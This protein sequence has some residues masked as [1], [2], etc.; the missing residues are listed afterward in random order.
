MPVI[1]DNKKIIPA[2]L[3]SFR[4]EIDT[5]E[6]G[7]VKKSV[8]VIT[9]TGT[10]VAY[11]GSPDG[12]GNFWTGSGYPPDTPQSEADNPDKRL[13]L[14]RD[15]LGALSNLF[16]QRG[17]TLEIQPY[18]GSASITAITR[19]RNFD[20]DQGL[21]YDKIDYT[22]TLEA[23]SIWFGSKEYPAVNN[24]IEETWVVEPNDDKQRTYKVTHTVSAVGRPVYNSNGVLVTKA[25]VFA[26]DNMVSPRLFFNNDIKNQSL[27][28]PDLD[29]WGLYDFVRVEN[30]DETNGRYSITESW[31]L[32]NGGPYLEDY[33]VSIRSSV[34][35]NLTTVS[36]DGVITGFNTDN[37]NPG[38]ASRF[39]NAENGLSTVLGLLFSRA[40][41]YSGVA[42]NSIP[43]STTIGKNPNTG[44]ITYSYE[45]NN[46]PST[47][48]SGAVYESVIV[49]DDYPADVFAR[50]VCVLRA[51]GPVLQPIG[52]ITEKR[53]TVQIDIQMPPMNQIFTPSKPSIS[54]ILA[55]NYPIGAIQGPY[56]EKNSESWSI[57]TGKYSCVV[58]WVYV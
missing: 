15:K 5:T 2:P 32:Y 25:W 48:V 12:D 43:L 34:L 17:K 10:I 7:E 13:A 58:T 26:R 30:I 1:Y 45:Y 28:K 44:V 39:A 36:I 50:H 19:L 16:N 49:T 24:D 14:L 29:G 53:R 27:A 3:A 9:L 42:L 40:Q 31:V 57:T 22:I 11:K 51:I 6:T 41:A 55:A 8:W 37:T 20:Y 46:R 18:D 56:V 4:L 52:T 38:T 47:T 23:D 54:A 21:W 35:E 33:N